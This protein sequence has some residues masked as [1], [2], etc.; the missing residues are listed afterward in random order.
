MKLVSG[1]SHLGGS[2]P[3]QFHQSTEQ[4]KYHLTKE[5]HMYQFDVQGQPVQYTFGQDGSR[6]GNSGGGYNRA[7]SSS[8]PSGVDPTM[9]KYR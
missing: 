8:G 6:A 4:P 1:V 7:T 5:N 3:H 9:S 2:Y